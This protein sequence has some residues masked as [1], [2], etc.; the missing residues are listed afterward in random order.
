MKITETISKFLDKIFLYDRWNIGYL[1]QTPE[2]LILT[3]KL[4][5]DVN[6]L[7][8]DT[9]DYAAD[10]FVI[11]V[12]SKTHLYYE[13]LNF[14][15][16]KGEIMMTDDM[17]FKS[18]KKVK[19]IVNDAIHLSYPYLFTVQNQLY[20]IPET[21]TARQVALYQIDEKDPCRFKKIRLLLEGEAFV[22]SSIVYFKNK[23]WLFSSMSRK[24]GK[25]YI[26]HADG[27]DA[28]FKPHSLNPI[29]VAFNVNRSAGRLF[30][31][32]QRLYMPTQNPE[33]C[34]GGSVMINEI[35]NISETEFQYQTAFELLPQPPYDK[36]LHTINF[37]GGLMVID[38]KR[39]VFSALGPLKKII[40][41]I[42]NLKF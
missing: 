36:G 42:R 11:Q 35:T 41:K 8:E 10:P 6:W 5:G 1:R 37:A 2:N 26:F 24:P 17:L 7:T 20:C 32:D 25:L 15:K 38:G 9:V 14:W 34:Y 12:N 29:N 31:V 27:L 40:G 28:P 39:K 19:G 13:E 4:N 3:Q 23:Y 22:D 16:G 30:I 33:K 18:K 21:A